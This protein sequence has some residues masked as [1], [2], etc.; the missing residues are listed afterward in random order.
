MVLSGYGE[1]RDEGKELSPHL[2]VKRVE[3]ELLVE[4]RLL[5]KAYDQGYQI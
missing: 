2:A 5:V 1:Y 4:V 3:V